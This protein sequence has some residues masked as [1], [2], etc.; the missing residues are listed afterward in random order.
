MD[1]GGNAPSKEDELADEAFKSIFPHGLPTARN[2]SGTAIVKTFPLEASHLQKLAEHLDSNATLGVENQQLRA[3]SST[4]RR[5]A[6]LL[7]MGMDEGQAGLICNYTPSTV[8]IL[9]SDPMF[10][11]LLEYYGSQ[12]D[13]EFASVAQQMAELG[14]DVIVELRDR[15][16]QKP[17]QF[18]VSSL[19][20]LMKALMDRT[21][22]GPTT[23]HN[24][25]AVTVA[26]GEHDLQRIKRDAAV[27]QPDVHGQVRVLTEEDR[28]ALGSVFALSASDVA[29][30][31]A[32]EGIAP[33]EGVGVRAANSGQAEDGM[34]ANS[35]AA[36]S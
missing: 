12:V 9:K 1:G 6:Q 31:P 24:V 28:R 19:T 33:G 36:L 32:R 25:R 35:R 26:L 2:Q 15:L 5:L 7:S 21:G 13:A 3:L 30:I 29:A 20:E 22:N 34:V 11:E 23:N 14:E 10:N 4:H 17:G 16:A 8:S 18:T 27:A